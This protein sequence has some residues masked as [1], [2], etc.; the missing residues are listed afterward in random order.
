MMEGVEA[1]LIADWT[2]FGLGGGVPGSLQ[3]TR[4]GSLKSREKEGAVTFITH[5][6]WSRDPCMTVKVVKERDYEPLVDLEHRRLWD[7]QGHLG[8]ELGATI[9][10]ALTLRRVEEKL[11]SVR[12]YLEGGSLLGYFKATGSRRHR[13]R[14]ILETRAAVEW[15]RRFNEATASMGRDAEGREYTTELRELFRSNWGL[16]DEA[17]ALFDRI[18]SDLSGQTLALRPSHGD[19]C[20][21]NLIVLDRGLGVIDW[22]HFH[23]HAPPLADLTNLLFARQSRGLPLERPGRLLP[24]HRLDGDS[25]YGRCFG[26]ILNEETRRCGLAADA[27]TALLGLGIAFSATRSQEEVGPRHSPLSRRAALFEDL[28]CWARERRCP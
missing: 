12:A 19:F 7:L 17:A 4:V 27:T 21:G 5:A 13:N 23:P 16:T 11:V 2:S 6:D 14:V 26:E 3:F 24:L 1:A 9:P 22:S 28:A 8:D 15:L 20:D 18:A 10:R 25:W